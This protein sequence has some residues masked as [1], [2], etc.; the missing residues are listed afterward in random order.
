MTRPPS[1]R[2][3]RTRWGGRMLTAAGR[4][5]AGSALD[6]GT[7]AVELS[8]DM[9]IW[10]PDSGDKTGWAAP[11]MLFILFERVGVRN[12]KLAGPTRGAAIFG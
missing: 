3:A 2:M 9:M 1:V 5:R 10:T 11:R 12:G 8:A 7:S 6:L 4:R